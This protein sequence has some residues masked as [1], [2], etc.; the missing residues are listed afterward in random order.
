MRSLIICLTVST[1]FLAGCLTMPEEVPD[2]YLVEKTAD[3]GKTIEKLKTDIIAKNQ[4]IHVL[5]DRVTDAGQKQK[6]EKGRTSILKQEKSLLEDK[7]KQYQLE[8]DT[9][10]MN[11]NAKAMV[12]NDY[13]LRAGNARLE[14]AIAALDLAEAQQEV[15]E[16]ELAVQVAELASAKAKV[17]KTYLVKKQSSGVPDDKKASGKGPET[18]DEKYVKYLEKQRETL[19]SKKAARDEAAL[20]LK[21]AEDKFKSGDPTK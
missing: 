16:A 21:V 17:A 1:V 4:E 11:E 5:K 7:Q 2:A 3:E 10:K 15:G 9:A 14:V 12:D 6:V 8:N 20:K 19:V 18:Y 13:Q